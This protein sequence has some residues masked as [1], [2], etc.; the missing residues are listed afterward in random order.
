MLPIVL[1]FT[2]CNVQRTA[3][4]GKYQDSSFH[5]ESAKTVDEVWSEVIDLLAAKGISIRIIEEPSGLIV[6]KESSL[7]FSTEVDG[8]LINPNAFVVVNSLDKEKY[9][10]IT[11]EWNI[12]VKK[13][14]EKTAV[15]A[16]LMEIKC[17]N[18]AIP[19]IEIKSTGVFEK[20]IADAVR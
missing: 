16:T 18:T 13:A 20:L 17:Y 4:I 11:G 12:R 9:L 7:T 10:Y 15:I 8:H 2:S 3:L 6:S 19:N 5:I 1:L 14:G